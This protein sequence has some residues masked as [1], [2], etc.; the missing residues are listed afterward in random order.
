MILAVDTLNVQYFERLMPCNDVLSDNYI[1]KS[2][3][4]CYSKAKLWERYPC[5]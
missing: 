3:K 5:I 1:D 4:A 2:G